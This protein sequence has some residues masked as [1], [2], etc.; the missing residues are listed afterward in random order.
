MFKIDQRKNIENSWSDMITFA[1]P[2]SNAGG[3]KVLRSDAKE[4]V[5]RLCV[6]TPPI[7]PK[8]SRLRIKLVE[9]LP[10]VV[11]KEE[12]SSD[13]ESTTA[14]SLPTCARTPC[15][16]ACFEPFAFV[17]T[18]DLDPSDS[19]VESPIDKEDDFAPPSTNESPEADLAAAFV[20][21]APEERT[22]LSRKRRKHVM[23]GLE[24]LST[25]DHCVQ[26]LCGLKSIDA[27]PPTVCIITDHPS[28]FQDNDF[29]VLD[30]GHDCC[31]FEA[32]PGEVNWHEIFAQHDFIVVAIGYSGN[33]TPLGHAR[34][35][36]EL[37]MHAEADD[38]T[39]FLRIDSSITTRREQR[40][41]QQT[42]YLT[43]HLGFTCNDEQVQKS[44]EDWSQGKQWTMYCLQ[45][46]VRG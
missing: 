22:T 23:E 36:H 28:V 46:W 5:G 20:A 24:N 37:E 13:T 32:M 44:F 11:F 10:R 1:Y 27:N 45:T 3:E 33:E 15:N 35:L 25:H 12:G 34:L 9:A 19:D 30:A 43:D 17:G 29:D 4:S 18:I 6:R 26:Y 39:R 31:N 41:S 2:P 14:D 38:R 21:I 7:P 8:P 42:P 16:L 40:V